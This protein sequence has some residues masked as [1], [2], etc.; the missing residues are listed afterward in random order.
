[1]R[2]LNV[3]DL[4]LSSPHEVAQKCKVNPS[5]VER[6]MDCMYNVGTPQNIRRLKDVQGEG[7]EFTTGDSRLDE[8]L[9]GGIR[10]G[11]I[12]EVAGE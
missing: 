9:G 7:E 6:M 11:M 8:A 2:I 12:W 5:A 1:G 4:L 10:T 3:E